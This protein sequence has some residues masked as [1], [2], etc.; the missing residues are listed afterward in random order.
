MAGQKDTSGIQ[1][2]M[3]GAS[4]LRH[5]FEYYKMERM[6]DEVSQSKIPDVMDWRVNKGLKFRGFLL[7]G[8]SISGASK[9]ED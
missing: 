5:P 1:V 4:E 2:R 6:Q 9:T 3:K 7:I 8:I